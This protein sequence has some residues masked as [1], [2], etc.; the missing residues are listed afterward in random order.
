M[1]NE[2]KKCQA[3]NDDD[4]DTV[5]GGITVKTGTDIGGDPVSKKFTNKG[6]GLQKN[7]KIN[8]VAQ[9]DKASNPAKE[10]QKGSSIA[11]DMQLDKDAVNKMA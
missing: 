8:K 4:L 9:V 7:K 3:L 10:I 11:K 2:T 5:V 6:A 1:A